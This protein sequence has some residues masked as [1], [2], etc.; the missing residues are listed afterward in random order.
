MNTGTVKVLKTLSLF[1]QRPSWGVTEVAREMGCSKNSAFQA[2]DT[3]VSEQYLIRDATGQR[4]QLSHLALGFIGDSEALDIRSLC[5][6]YML[7]LQ[8]LT[9]ES[10]FLS[11]LVGRHHVCIDALRGPGVAIGYSPLS[12]PLPLHAGAG[13]RLLLAQLEDDEIRRYIELEA[14]LKKITPTTIVDIDELWE[15]IKLVRNRG[16]ARGYEDFSTGANYLS[17]PVLGPMARPLAAVT[18][19]GPLTRFTREVADAMI[20]AIRAIMADLNQH[21]RMFPMVPLF[22]L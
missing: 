3:L 18:I 11:I 20:P 2:L 21:S 6:P 12:Q 7:R 8:E 14:P 17:F 1:S 16:F 9:D 19:G 5:H 10:V 4:Y 13:S 22:R 15:E